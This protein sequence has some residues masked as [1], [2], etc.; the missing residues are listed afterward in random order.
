M[1][2]L[3][4]LDYCPGFCLS[5]NKEDSFIEVV[6]HTREMKTNNMKHLYKRDWF[7]IFT[8]AFFFILEQ[9]SSIASE[10][11]LMLLC[12]LSY[13]FP[14]GVTLVPSPVSGDTDILPPCWQSLS[15]GK[16]SCVAC[17]LYWPSAASPLSLTTNGNHQERLRAHQDLLK[18][19]CVAN[20][21]ARTKGRQKSVSEVSVRHESADVAC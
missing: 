10:S 19:P 11:K 9:P 2:E 20:S 13:F 3:C 7:F 18:T 5:G 17:S 8:D 6:K 4:T 15:S 21:T 16:S 12:V 1:C 14:S